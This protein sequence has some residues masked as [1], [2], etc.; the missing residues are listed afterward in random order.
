MVLF[1][2]I[3]TTGQVVNP[4]MSRFFKPE[5]VKH[6]LSTELKAFLHV[7]QSISGVFLNCNSK[8]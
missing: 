7:L 3:Q 6:F 2:G 5:L 4:C 8:M 1:V